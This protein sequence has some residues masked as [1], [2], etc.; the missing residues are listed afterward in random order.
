MK[1][2]LTYA[3]FGLFVDGVYSAKYSG[4]E[5]AC[6]FYCCLISSAVFGGAQF[7]LFFQTMPSK[8]SSRQC[9]AV[10]EATGLLFRSIPGKIVSSH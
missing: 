1:S 2:A 9:A 10:V 8:A 6:I 3:Y 4:F 7:I 5:N